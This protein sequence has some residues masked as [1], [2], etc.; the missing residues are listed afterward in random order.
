MPRGAAVLRVLPG[1]FNTF[2]ARAL[3]FL[4]IELSLHDAGA[5]LYD[6]F[7]L[8]RVNRITDFASGINLTDCS[9]K[10]R[11]KPPITRRSNSGDHCFRSS[12]PQFVSLQAAFAT[13][14]ARPLR[15]D[16]FPV[17]NLSCERKRSYA[18]MNG[19]GCYHDRRSRLEPVSRLRRERII[20][21]FS[22]TPS[23]L[24]HESFHP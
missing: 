24:H 22:K 21:A 14:T 17:I 10:P 6:S 19:V 11:P 4:V 1:P 16:P 18:L 13:R 8:D 15:H 20:L 3:H 12:P 9:T 2:C 23:S 5:F 7:A